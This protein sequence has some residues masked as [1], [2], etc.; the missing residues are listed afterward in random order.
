MAINKLGGALMAITTVVLLSTMGLSQTAV[1]QAVQGTLNIPS[2]CAVEVNEELTDLDFGDVNS[3]ELV[4]GIIELTNTGNEQS[5]LAITGADWLA[6]S[7]LSTVIDISNTSYESTNDGGPV[8]GP[9]PVVLDGTQQTLG[10]LDP[11]DTGDF[12]TVDYYVDIVLAKAF[13]G[14]ASVE[15]TITETDCQDQ[16]LVE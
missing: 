4:A 1:G 6:D 5:T 7:D 14:P 11:D 3:G 9:P 12:M 13:S 2:T 10:T 8:V 16:T 15:L